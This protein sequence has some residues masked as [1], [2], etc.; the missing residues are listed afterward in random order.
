MFK[1]SLSRTKSL[2]ITAIALLA[3][4]L[5]ASPHARAELASFFFG[6]P[7]INVRPA[8]DTVTITDA[9]GATL[10]Y[11]LSSNVS[12]EREPQIGSLTILDITTLKEARAF[13]GVEGP[14]PTA[15]EGTAMIAYTE[16]GKDGKLIMAGLSQPYDGFWARYRPN[17]DHQTQIN[18]SNDWQVTSEQVTIGGFPGLQ[19]TAKGTKGNTTVELWLLNGNWVYE[20]RCDRGDLAR[21]VKIV[22]SMK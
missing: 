20:L 5:V 3:L 17:G 21:L 10:T 2:I 8:D 12:F 1:K 19:I 18:Y 9:S 6:L 16:I 14:L 7:I 11:K 13:L 15:I 4:G 22:E